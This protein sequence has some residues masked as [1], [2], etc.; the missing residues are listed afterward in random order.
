MLRVCLF[1]AV[2]A[3]LTACTSTVSVPTQ[4]TKNDIQEAEDRMRDS[5]R[6]P[7]SGRFKNFRAY[8]LSNGETAICADVNA[9]NGFGGMTGFTPG[10][11]YFGK[12]P[13]GLVF[14]DDT[15]RFSCQQL[16]RGVSYRY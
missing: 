1:A 4:V 2:T 12:V 5:L 7:E 14:L 16:A 11:V 10:V 6:N 9:E 13:G 8:A 15:G 3:G